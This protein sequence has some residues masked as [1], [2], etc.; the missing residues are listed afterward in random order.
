M[1]EVWLVGVHA[2]DGLL[3]RTKILHCQVPSAGTWV[4]LL[5]MVFSSGLLAP[6]SGRASPVFSRSWNVLD[7]YS[8]VCDPFLFFHKMK[9]S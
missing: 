6:V 8:K 1:S 4:V 2:V 9:D 3:C 7:F 5:L